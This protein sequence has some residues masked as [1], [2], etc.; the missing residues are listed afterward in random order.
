MKSYFVLFI[1]L[2]FSFEIYA[3]DLMPVSLRLVNQESEIYTFQVTNQTDSII[4]ITR[5]EGG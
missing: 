1:V 4:K 2:L 5:I 3:T